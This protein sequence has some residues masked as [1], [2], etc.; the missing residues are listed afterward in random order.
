EALVRR[1]WVGPLTR[2]RIGALAGRWRIGALAGRRRVG[3]L[4][5]RR[6]VGALAGRL[7]AA[8]GTR[9]AGIG[10]VR[11]LRHGS[12]RTIEVSRRSLPT[13][14]DPWRRQSVSALRHTPTSPCRP[15]GTG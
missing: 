7:V 11:R 3:A 12:S 2:W 4:A 9:L 10:L 15:I 6:R 1:R 14:C 5:G 8:P 13:R